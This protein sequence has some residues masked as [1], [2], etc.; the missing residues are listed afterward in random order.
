MNNLDD[1]IK[2]VLE[3]YPSLTAQLNEDGY[4][5]TGNVTLDKTYND[6]PLYE[7]YNLKILVPNTFPS[8]SPSVFNIG[9]SMPPGFDHFLNDGS[10]C[11]G[12]QCE[13]RSFLDEHPTVLEFLDE[14]LMSFLYSASFFRL[15]GTFPFGERSHG[16]A[17]IIEAYKDRYRVEDD[18]LLAQ[19]LL[20]LIGEVPY[21]GHHL[22]PCGSGKIL[23]NCHGRPVLKDIQSNYLEEYKMDAFRILISLYE[24][25]E[26]MKKVSNA[27]A[28]RST[29]TKHIQ[30][31]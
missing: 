22:C 18:R 26:E 20:I 4:V 7:T 8:S 10:F 23:R 30:N 11:L 31:S 19:L 24:S 9:D 25:A 12:A 13:I 16:T 14:L 3:R 2:A 5:L 15:Y 21:R 27:H 28:K 6:V 29:A 17:G 1:Q